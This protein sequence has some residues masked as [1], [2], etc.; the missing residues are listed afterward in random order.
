MSA[1]LA[2]EITV[3]HAELTGCIHEA[4]LLQRVQE[5]LLLLVT[6]ILASTLASEAHAH[7]VES[8]RVTELAEGAN[9]CNQ[10]SALMTEIVA[11]GAS[12]NASHMAHVNTAAL[13]HG[14]H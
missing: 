10:V 14:A 3:V 9:L 13:H 2:H 6:D 5:H 4:L 1:A 11:A 7:L 8:S 12:M